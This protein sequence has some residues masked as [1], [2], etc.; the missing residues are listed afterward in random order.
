MQ[1]M[2]TTSG[3]VQ[4]R[5]IDAYL[6]YGRK[7]NFP[8][9]VREIYKQGDYVN[10]KPE[11]PL[12]SLWSNLS[13]D[14]F[15]TSL[16]KLPICIN[17]II[18]TKNTDQIPENDLFQQNSD[19][20]V[21]KHFNFINNSYHMQNYF[22]IGY[23]F[24]GSCQL[25]FEKEHHLVSEGELYIIA[26]ESLHDIVIDDDSSVVILIQTRKSTFENSFFTLLTQ[27]DM[28]SYFFRMILNHQ[29]SANYLL[30]Y[31]KNTPDIKSIIKNLT[32]EN[33]K[34]DRYY[35]NCCISWI[36]IL[37]S[38]ILRNYSD[39]VEFYNYKNVNAQFPL[40]LQYIQQ[41]YKTLSLKS[42]ADYFHYSEAHLCTLIKKN[43]GLNFTSLLNK[44]KISKSIEYLEN[45]EL[46]IT[47]IAEYV[48]YNSEDHFSRTF[49]KY[50]HQSPQQYRK[51]LSTKLAI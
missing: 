1:N 5:L 38:I 45:T 20:F 46:S 22:E 3:I 47:S 2:Y 27:Q 34:D 6:Q 23:V 49:K 17:S 31:T 37:F 36:N 40:I 29:T 24:K 14:E 12:A 32:M 26:P 15:I 48:G 35:N 30:F 39:T 18:E 8:E 25:K 9:I 41:N 16:H 4:S 43:T 51:H 28:L 19:V 42:L 13:D 11:L 7:K 10:L 44:L 50:Y 21:F 33:Y